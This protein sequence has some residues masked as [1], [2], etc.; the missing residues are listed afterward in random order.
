M[1]DQEPEEVKSWNEVREVRRSF[2]PVERASE[3][4]GRVLLVERVVGGF[5]AGGE[6]V[7]QM[8]SLTS[9]AARRDSWKVWRTNCWDIVKPAGGWGMPG[10][11]VVY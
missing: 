6:F 11:K 5:E 8:A 7:G 4:Y 1:V 3:G 2:S 9:G 10:E